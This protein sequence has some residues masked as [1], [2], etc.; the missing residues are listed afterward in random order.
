MQAGGGAQVSGSRVQK[1]RAK[2]RELGSGLGAR[3]PG[4]VLRSGEPAP[5]P[6]RA[7][8]ASPRLDSILSPSP[9]REGSFHAPCSCTYAHT[10]STYAPT[11]TACVSE[12]KTN[13]RHDHR[14]TIQPRTRPLPRPRPRPSC[15]IVAS[16][17]ANHIPVKVGNC[18]PQRAQLRANARSKLNTRSP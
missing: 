9:V 12:Q 6:K 18:D 17:C 14:A 7:S 10:S 2:G 15:L 11:P 16:A 4:G 1:Q 3:R 5:G 8:L 13:S